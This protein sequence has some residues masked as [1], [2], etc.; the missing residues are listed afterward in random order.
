M[1]FAPPFHLHLVKCAVALVPH[2]VH[3]VKKVLLVF[4]LELLNWW[5]HMTFFKLQKG[6]CKANNTQKEKWCLATEMELCH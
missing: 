3:V 1:E 4:I 6:G 5:A 2:Q